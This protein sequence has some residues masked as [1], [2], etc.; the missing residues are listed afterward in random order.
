MLSSQT[1][2]A[3]EEAVKRRREQGRSA[4]RLF[5]SPLVVEGRP[6]LKASALFPLSLTPHPHPQTWPG[7]PR[8]CWRLIDTERILQTEPH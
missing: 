7:V 6:I 8:A 1:R 4:N 5:P 2:A 3:W